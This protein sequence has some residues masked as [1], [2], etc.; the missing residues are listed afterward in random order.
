VVKLSFL[1]AAK[2]E[3]IHAEK[4]RNAFYGKK[5]FI[6]SSMLWMGEIGVVEH[7][8]FLNA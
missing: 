7:R 1:T 8:W 5:N 4:R 6:S 3:E 2:S